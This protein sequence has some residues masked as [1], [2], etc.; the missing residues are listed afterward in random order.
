MSL[1]L[2][3]WELPLTNCPI[4]SIESIPPSGFEFPIGTTT[5]IQTVVDSSGLRTSCTFPVVVID[6]ADQ[7]KCGNGFLDPGEECEPNQLGSDTCITQGFP[8]GGVLDCVTCQFDTD[9]CAVCGDGRVDGTEL[10]DGSNLNSQACTDFGYTAGQLQCKPDCTGF[11]L[12]GCTKCGDGLIQGAE[13]C[14]GPLQLNGQSCSSLLGPGT[15]GGLL[16]C[17]K[18]CTFD[19][20]SCYVPSI[21]LP[22]T[23]S[24]IARQSLGIR[25]KA[26]HFANDLRVT[27]AISDGLGHTKTYTGIPLAMPNGEFDDT[28]DAPSPLAPSTKWTVS[29]KGEQTLYIVTT[30]QFTVATS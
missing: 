11:L 30:G 4:Q 20:S 28:F 8:L 5:V 16:S 25:I 18:Y 17:S 26:T 10:C 19:T 3:L 12:T 21:I 7:C 9:R 6:G 13:Q 14:D 1:S 24:V 23:G 27:V 22:I 2:S 29:V 15:Y